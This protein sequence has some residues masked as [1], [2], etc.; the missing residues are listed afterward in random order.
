[1]FIAKPRGLLYLMLANVKVGDCELKGLQAAGAESSFKGGG[2]G[3]M[4][5]WL[6][7]HAEDEPR[8]AGSRVRVKPKRGD[9]LY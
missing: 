2:R 6:I 5:H 4:I 3:R 9:K 1:M 8:I 7:P